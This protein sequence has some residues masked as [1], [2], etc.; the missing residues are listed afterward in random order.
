MNITTVMIIRI[1]ENLVSIYLINWSVHT[2]L[3]GQYI[4]D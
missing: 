1:L 3:V 4:L 2:L